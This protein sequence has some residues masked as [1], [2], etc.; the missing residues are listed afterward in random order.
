MAQIQRNQP[1]YEQLMWRIKAQVASGVLIIG[2]KLPSVREM[3]L[4]EGLNPNTVAKAYRAL[5]NQNVIETVTGRGT[6][7]R[8]NDEFTADEQLIASLQEQLGEVVIEAKR[9]SIS[10]QELHQWLDSCYSGKL[11]SPRR[12]H[13]ISH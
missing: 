8:A 5:E 10:V 11:D 4:I 6:F 3:A 2:E 1:L 12:M 13:D 7:I 9:A